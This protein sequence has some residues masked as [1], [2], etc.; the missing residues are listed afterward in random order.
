MSPLQKIGKKAL[1]TGGSSGLGRA[2]VQMLLEEGFEVWATSRSK[3]QLKSVP[4]FHPLVLDLT[5]PEKVRAFIDDF[6]MSHP[7]LDLLIN[8]AGY[9]VFY[10]LEKMPDISQQLQVMLE[11]PILLTQVV[12]RKMCE[13]D[14]G[15][16]VNVTSLAVSFPLPFMSIYNAAKAGLSSFTR[17]IQLETTSRNVRIVDFQPG[18]YA[19][20][21]NEKI[22]RNHLEAHPLIASVWAQNQ[23]HVHAGPPPSRA[24]RDLKRVLLGKKKLLMRSGG[25]FQRSLAPFF[26]RFLSWGVLYRFIRCYFHFGRSS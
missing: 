9:G 6:I 7:D 23:V 16:I 3:D 18:D 15:I 11:M 4:H 1:V 13:R 20:D 24:A 26:A 14:H 2:F 19:T 8:N 22:V 5:E 17:S 25:F 12:Y 21:F 10:P